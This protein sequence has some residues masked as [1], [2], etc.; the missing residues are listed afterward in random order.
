MKFLEKKISKIEF[1]AILLK[2]AYDDDIF[3]LASQLAFHIVLSIFPFLIFVM[4][5]IGFSH[6]NSNDVVNLLKTVF[7]ENVFETIDKIIVEVTTSQSKGILGISIFATVWTS[8]SGFR[9]VIKGV[10]KA[11]NI[12]DKRSFIKKVIISFMSTIA[13]ALIILFTLIFLVFGRVIGKYISN[14]FPMGNFISYIWNLLRGGILTFILILVIAAIYKFT[15][16]IRLKW[17]DVL[18]GA[19]ISTTGWIIVSVAFS[20]Y[21]N[22]FN[23][24]S[25]IYG[26]LAAIFILMIW[27]FLT[28]FIFLAGVEINSVILLR[29]QGRFN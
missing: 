21:I 23:N 2:K 4:S 18:P 26:S 15:P 17:K 28:S 10:N 14:L 6:I 5:L 13:L 3:A 8:S 19:I 20:Y 1:I 12:V 25:R 22:N 7:P 16:S 27:T 29:R 9:A 11:N 24:Y